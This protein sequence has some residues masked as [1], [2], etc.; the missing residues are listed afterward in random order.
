MPPKKVAAKHPAKTDAKTTDKKDFV[1]S[2]DEVE[3]LLNVA[4]DYKVAQAA[5]SVDWE[6][7]KSKYKDIL[8]LYIDALP[9]AGTTF[10]IY[11]H[12]KDEIKLQAITSKLKAVGIK[13]RQAV[14]SGRRSGLASFP[15]LRNLCG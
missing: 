8:Q 12:K 7:V 11:P 6:S 14:D 4:I 1:W 2:D 10:K 15:G 9:A 3:L 5:E 13:F